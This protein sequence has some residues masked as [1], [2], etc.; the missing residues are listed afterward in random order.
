MMATQIPPPSPAQTDEIERAREELGESEG[1]ALAAVFYRQRHWDTLHRFLFGGSVP[2]PIGTDIT[3]SPSPV[4]NEPPSIWV[5]GWVVTQDEHDEEEPYKRLPDKEYLK[6]LAYAWVWEPLLFVPKSRQL[7]VT[8][9]FCAIGAH[10]LIARQARRCAFVS[11]KSED[12]D[13]GLLTRVELVC[14]MLPPWA[15]PVQHIEGYLTCPE[16]N[17][18]I[19]AI[20]ENSEKGLRSYTFS[21]IFSDEAAFQTNPAPGYRAAL[22]TIKGVHSSSRYTAVSTSDGEEWFHSVLSDS[23]KI[24]TPAGK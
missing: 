8:W 11:K 7:M 14:E 20:G 10:E 1:R 16:T 22:A 2:L 4:S 15:P 23:G 6:R 9:L 21:W 18:V 5:P 3:R 12:A 17:S 13:R 24:P 19:M